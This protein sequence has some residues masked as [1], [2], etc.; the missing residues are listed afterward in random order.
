MLEEEEYSITVEQFVADIDEKVSTIDE[1]IAIVKDMLVSQ[2]VT[3]H[4]DKALFY[5]M[6]LM[7][8][9]RKG[10]VETKERALLDDSW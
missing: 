9:E 5:A 2:E 8:R 10:L 7:L 6:N 1:H 3:H 4:Q